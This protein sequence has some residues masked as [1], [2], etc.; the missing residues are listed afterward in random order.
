MLKSKIPQIRRGLRPAAGRAVTRAGGFV[1]RLAKQLAPYD[2]R[3]GRPSG[4]HLRDTI[5]L[6]GQAGDLTRVVTAGR[7]LPDPRAI[8]N[9]YGGITI[10]YPPQPYMTPAS[11]AISL[12][13]EL[14]IE[15]SKLYKKYGV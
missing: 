3:P 5:Q 12:P 13:R 2:D 10:F 15:I 9:E 7:G 6:E 8:L 4:P 11:R 14:A 1:V